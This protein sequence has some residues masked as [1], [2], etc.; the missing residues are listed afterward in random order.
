MLT[1]LRSYFKI[2]WYKSALAAN[3]WEGLYYHLM[4]LE[5]RLNLV[6]ILQMM[7]VR[8]FVQ[9]P[10]SSRFPSKPLPYN[11]SNRSYTHLITSSES[12]WSS[13]KYRPINRKNYLAMKPSNKSRNDQSGNALQLAVDFLAQFGTTTTCGIANMPGMSKPLLANEY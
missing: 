8:S 13:T 12:Y 10:N 2:F 11:L 4:Y 3:G 9:L 7:Y 5:S 6:P 1:Y